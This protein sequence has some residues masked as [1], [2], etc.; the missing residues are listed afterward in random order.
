[1]GR[2]LAAKPAVFAEFQFIRRCSLIF[3]G[4][5]IATFAFGTCKVD[6]DSHRL[7]P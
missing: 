4:A 1:M 7:T 3:G 2:V 6:N 5:V